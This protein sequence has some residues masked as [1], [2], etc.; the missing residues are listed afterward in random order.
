MLQDDPENKGDGGNIASGLKGTKY[1]NFVTRTLQ[2][3][4]YGMQLLVHVNSTAITYIEDEEFRKRYCEE[5][6][7][8][9]IK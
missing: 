2:G 4:R 1:I 7:D 5:Y 6:L 8:L 3:N 9:R